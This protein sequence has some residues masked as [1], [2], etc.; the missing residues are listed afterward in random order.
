MPGEP[1]SAGPSFGWRSSQE[2]IL[3]VGDLE[4]SGDLFVL[5]CESNGE[6]QRVGR[7]ARRPAAEIIVELDG[8]AV[9]RDRVLG[10]CSGS[11]RKNWTP[12]AAASWYN[13]SALRLKVRISRYRTR[14]CL[15]L[16]A[17]AHRLPDHRLAAIARTAAAV[18]ARADATH[19]RDV[20]ALQRVAL[21]EPTFVM[22]LGR[23]P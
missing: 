12:L 16:L 2:A 21:F 15:P 9:P 19:E 1:A 5:R 13:S 20:L 10:A 14:T 22:T 7:N 3:A 18:L 17:Q 11:M 4:L 23:L 8:V 6:H